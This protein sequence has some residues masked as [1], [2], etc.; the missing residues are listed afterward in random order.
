M[1]LLLGFI[2]TV[3]IVTS[4][5]SAVINNIAIAY[6]LF[7]LVI[8]IVVL[9]VTTYDIY[10]YIHVLLLLLLLFSMLDSSLPRTCSSF[11]VLVVS[12]VVVSS[13]SHRQ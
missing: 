5:L 6:V 3:F 1:A 9:C 10:M 13:S 12:I 8:V 2:M 7:T 11:L 4:M